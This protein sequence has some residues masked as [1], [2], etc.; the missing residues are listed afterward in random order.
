[1]VFRLLKGFKRSHLIFNL[2][3]LLS[4]NHSV[5]LNECHKLLWYCTQQ[6][7]YSMLGELYLF[8]IIV[9]KFVEISGM[10]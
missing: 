7:T 4:E 6:M 5:Q 8:Q 9:K 3:R 2:I 1:M 10:N